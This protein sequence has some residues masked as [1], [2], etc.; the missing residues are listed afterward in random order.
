[1]TMTFRA[2]LS[3]LA[4]IEA[5]TP[6]PEDVERVRDFVERGEGL[7]KWAVDR[8]AMSKPLDAMLHAGLRDVLRGIE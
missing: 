2:A 6:K 8:V 1:M 7:A 3:A 4:R 5:G